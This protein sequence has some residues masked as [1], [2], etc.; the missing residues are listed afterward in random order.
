MVTCTFSSG[1]KSSHFSKPTEIASIPP[2]GVIFDVGKMQFAVRKVTYS[3]AARKLYVHFEDVILTTELEY[4]LF[5]DNIL[6][7]SGW[8]LDLESVW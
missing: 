5:V 1:R 7:K 2:I 8:R 6:H 4:K 3:D